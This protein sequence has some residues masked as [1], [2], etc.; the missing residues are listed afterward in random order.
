MEKLFNVRQAAEMLAVSPEF[1]EK[2]YRAGSLRVVRLGPRV[3]RIPEEELNR[4]CR[5]GVT[6]VAAR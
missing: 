2:M 4:L 1:L 3:V 5:E 6:R